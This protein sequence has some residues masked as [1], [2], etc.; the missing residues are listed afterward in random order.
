[1]ALP[2]PLT[3]LRHQDDQLR[4]SPLLSTLDNGGNESHLN[5]L[6]ILSC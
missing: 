5:G 6:K 3:A 1:M 4:Q 2:P